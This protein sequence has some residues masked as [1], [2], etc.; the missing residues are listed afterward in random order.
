MSAADALDAAP[1]SPTAPRLLYALAGLAAD[2]K[3]WTQALAMAKRLVADFA[4][5]ERADDALERVA[6][7]AARERAWPVAYEAYALLRQTYPRSPFVA[8]SGL[9]FGEA[10]VAT[11][12]AAEGR[13][14]LE[15][16]LAVAV[17][18]DPRAAQA[19]IALGRA[20]ELTGD[21]AGA[22]DAYAQ[23]A[24]EVPISRWSTETVFGYARLLTQGRRYDEAR[25]LLEPL[26]RTAPAPMA[27]DAA[28]AL[29][30][31]LQ[32]QGD[33]AAAVE[34]LMTAAYLAPDSPAGRR[35]LV[36]AGQ[37]FAGLKQADSAAV[38]YRKLLAQSNVPPDL[39]TAARQGLAE[40]GR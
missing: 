31:T 22:L 16:L 28:L 38:V 8:D 2:Q 17:P 24:R 29:G 11:G 18:G 32:A 20:R 30:E 23:A 40:L 36:A 19:R 12:R 5:D 3:D 26:I 13:K 6:G 33:G 21:R 35:A 39:V 37:A 14:T 9:A 7:A 27:V 25:G 4:D 1:R 10:Q 15:Q 34:Y